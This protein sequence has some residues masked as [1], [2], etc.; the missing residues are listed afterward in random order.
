MMQSFGKPA[1]IFIL[2]SSVNISARFKRSSPG[3]HKEQ[4][5]APLVDF[6]CG[7][8]PSLAYLYIII[9]SFL[10]IDL[11]KFCLFSSEM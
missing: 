8:L 2:L 11:I 1:L 5:K 7:A 10:F 4:L 6:K 3:K 9:S